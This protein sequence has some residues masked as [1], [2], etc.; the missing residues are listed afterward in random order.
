VDASLAGVS[1]NLV[2]ELGVGCKPAVVG[3]GNQVLELADVEVRRHFEDRAGWA[4]QGKA[5]AAAE[6]CG[7]EPGA[8]DSEVQAFESR[9]RR[10]RDADRAG[11]LGEG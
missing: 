3:F 5:P 7:V 6:V 2:V 1:R 4:G 8:V 9:F 11:G 10:D